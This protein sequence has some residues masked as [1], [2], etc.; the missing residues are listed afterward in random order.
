MPYIYQVNFH[1]PQDR[2]DELR[3]G[4]SLERILAYLRALLPSEPG[5]VTSQGMYSVNPDERLH[6]V[7]HT[8]CESYEDLVRYGESSLSEDKVL[9]EFEPHLSDEEIQVHVYSEID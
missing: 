8:V 2:A 1:F 5:Y 4:T 6:I 9:L 3:I 7:F